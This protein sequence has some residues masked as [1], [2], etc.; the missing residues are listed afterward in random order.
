VPPK[1]TSKIVD[2]ANHGEVAWQ[3][4]RALGRRDVL[5][6]VKMQHPFFV[7]HVLVHSSLRKIDTSSLQSW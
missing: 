6:T 4:Q 5:H 3:L 7:L 1:S 2:Q